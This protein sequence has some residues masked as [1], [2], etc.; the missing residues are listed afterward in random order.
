M[1]ATLAEEGDENNKIK[2]FIVIESAYNY[3]FLKFSAFPTIRK[4]Y[5]NEKFK[6]KI[7]LER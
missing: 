4:I 6:K 5:K 2:K 3:E 7:A 1:H